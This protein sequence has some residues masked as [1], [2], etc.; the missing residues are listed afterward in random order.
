M[1]RRRLA[2]GW[3]YLF[4]LGLFCALSTGCGAAGCGSPEGV[5]AV[6]G[7]PRPGDAAVAPEPIVFA[8]SPVMQKALAFVKDKLR[9]PDGSVRTNLKDVATTDDLYLLG[10]NATSEHQGLLL[11]VAAAMND[12]ETF[13]RTYAFV[14][15]NLFS[16]RYG[17]IDYA[18]FE[19]T[20]KPFELPDQDGLMWRVNAPLDDMRVAR[21]LIAG[22]TVFHD[23]RYRDLALRIGQGLLKTSISSPLDF[24]A[25]AGGLV[26]P[27][28]YYRDDRE[29]FSTTTYKI[30]VNY[31]DLW[32]MKWFALFDSRWQ[33]VIDTSIRMM[34]DAQISDQSGGRGQFH[35]VL[36]QDGMVF[37][38]GW[39]Y[40]DPPMGQ[41]IVAIQSLW[42]AIHLARAG[43]T[44]QAQAALD[45]YK[46]FYTA[47]G[48]IPHF[49][50][51]DGTLPS[52]PEFSEQPVPSGAPPEVRA[53]WGTFGGAIQQGEARVYAQVARLAL[54][55]GDRGFAQKIISEKILPDQQTDPAAANFG[56]IGLRT[57]GTDDADGFNVLEALLALSLEQGATALVRQASPVASP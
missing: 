24:P 47:N 8:T 42:T 51:P 28:A 10:W 19:H 46:R 13:E 55:L 23:A 5:L 52:E 50:N 49:L 48:R 33:G 36:L 44:K 38:G 12:R 57:A 45:F 27:G 15:K 35:C 56:Y 40:R 37:D 2:K 11:W 53:K 32:T 31:A 25:Y 3:E 16:Q 43:Q 7:S 9:N 6:D 34:S 54:L 17:I 29:D 39:E 1:T 18:Y 21:G 26:T 4:T 20:Q 22:W 30:P 14:L 41:K